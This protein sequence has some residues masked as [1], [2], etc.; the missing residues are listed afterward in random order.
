M[1]LGSY[2]KFEMDR[3]TGVFLCTSCSLCKD[4]CPTQSIK[5][6]SKNLSSGEI[7]I[8]N[9]TA[10]AKFELN[11]T[12]C[13]QCDICIDVCPVD[14]IS[15]NGKYALELFSNEFID[16]KEFEKKKLK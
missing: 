6:D 15:K 8:F 16:L 12:T 9:G 10:P 7:D 11:L 1:T 3:E 14:A 4:I 5:V 13:T 2:P